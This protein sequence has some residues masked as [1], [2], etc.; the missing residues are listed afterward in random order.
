M[1]TEVVAA[2]TDTYTGSVFLLSNAAISW[3]S[4]KQRTVALSSIEAEYIA[5]SNAAKE[6]I[7]LSRF[8]SE[9]GF[10]TLSRISLHNDNQGAEKLAVNPVFHSRSKH[11]DIRCHFIRQALSEHPIDL[12]YTLTEEMIADVLTKA[13]PYSKYSFCID[14]LRVQNVGISRI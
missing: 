8:L 10:A 1:P 11:M 7:Y 14:R 6:A 3:E 13:L 4:R 12:I 5:L 2:W 9:I